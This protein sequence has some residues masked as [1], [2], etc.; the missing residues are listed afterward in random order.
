MYRQHRVIDRPVPF[1]ATCAQLL[2]RVS[3][4]VRY[5]RTPAEVLIPPTEK[6]VAVCRVVSRGDPLRRMLRIYCGVLISSAPA[7]IH[8]ISRR[9]QTPSASSIGGQ[10]QVRGSFRG[11]RDTHCEP[12]PH[13]LA[14]DGEVDGGHH[15]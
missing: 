3:Q 10:E 4:R 9:R 8:A 14:P 13:R 7:A 15:P 1:L 5:Y 11:Q 2:R 6:S 12:E